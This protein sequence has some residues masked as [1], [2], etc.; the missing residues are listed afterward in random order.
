MNKILVA[1]LCICF[2]LGS[3]NVLALKES[4]P[5]IL[6][7]RISSTMM[8]VPLPDLTVV[9]VKISGIPYLT[10]T[11]PSHRTVLVVPLTI[12]FTNLGAGTYEWFNV[13]G[14]GKSIDGDAH[15]DVILTDMDLGVP[16]QIVLG[17]PDSIE[18]I[19]Y[20]CWRLFF[21]PRGG[22]LC[23]QL[24][25]G[26]VKSYEVELLM[27]SDEPPRELNR[28]Y[29]DWVDTNEERAECNRDH[30]YDCDY[31]YPDLDIGTRYEI[32]AMVDY[33]LDPDYDL[34]ECWPQPLFGIDESDETNNE[35][36]ITGVWPKKGTFGYFQLP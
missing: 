22:V 32:H 34:T 29:P 21:N 6:E 16:V 2:I 18:N 3:Y 28:V 14:W 25:S 5:K 35:L 27:T 20:P 31:E 9:S 23:D 13:G 12:D 4:G 36:V 26:E 10:G 15:G 7:T 1:C 30:C 19:P 8:G 33:N 11:D 17:D 24:A